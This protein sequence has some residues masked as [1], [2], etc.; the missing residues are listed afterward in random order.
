MLRFLT[1][2]AK[3]AS[4][5]AAAQDVQYSSEATTAC[6]FAQGTLDGQKTCIGRSAQA[7]MDVNDMGSMPVGLGGCLMRLT[8]AQ[9]LYF[10]SLDLGE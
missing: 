3:M 2:S 6:V 4:G 5:S 10:V 8:G 9:A 7:C 1:F